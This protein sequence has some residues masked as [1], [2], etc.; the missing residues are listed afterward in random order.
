M[1]PRTVVSPRMPALILVALAVSSLLGCDMLLTDP[2]PPPATVEISFQVVEPALGGSTEAFAKVRRAFVRL[3]RNDDTVR[4]TVLAVTPVEN[5]IRVPVALEV[6][7][8]VESLGIAATLGYETTSLF[9]GATVVRIEPG[10]PTTAVVDVEAIAATVVGEA[11]VV[12]IP[13]VGEPVQLSSAVLFASGDTITGLSGSWVSENPQ[14]I[15]VTTDGLATAFEL[16]QARL[17]VSYDIFGDTIVAA[18]SPVDTIE[19]VPTELALQSR[20]T[21]QLTATLLDELGN[22]LVGRSVRWSSLDQ[23]VAVV[24]QTGL[25]SA[26]GPGTTAIV[27]TSEDAITRVP[28]TV[29]GL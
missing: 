20:E 4:D 1:S 9:R 7:E 6:D 5:E 29:S 27:A 21:A 14:I 10:E 2:A 18:T 22:V 16:G 3:A 12:Y 13:N 19:V 25:V 8:R 26:L 17:A 23:A 24:D 15:S 11:P 28:V